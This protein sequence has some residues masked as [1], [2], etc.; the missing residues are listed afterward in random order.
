MCKNPHKTHTKNTNDGKRR[1]TTENDGKRRKVT[2]SG[3]KQSGQMRNR[4]SRQSEWVR[5]AAGHET[6]QM[7]QLMGCGSGQARS[8]GTWQLRH[9]VYRGG[10][11]KGSQGKGPCKPT[12][13]EQ[14]RSKCFASRGK[15][16]MFSKISKAKL[17]KAIG[18][19][20]KR[21]PLQFASRD[22]FTQ[23]L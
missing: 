9:N 20:E 14:W 6:K 22:R 2:D 15:G 13:S 10:R 17:Y 3:L 5:C 11:G 18:V 7:P 1:R 4:T 23:N 8:M 21:S 12:S 19:A 16:P